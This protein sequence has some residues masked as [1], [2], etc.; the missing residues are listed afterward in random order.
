VVD[1]K[2]QRNEA[3]DTFTKEGFEG[4]PAGKTNLWADG[5][6]FKAV[7][8]E[9]PDVYDLNGYDR[10]VAMTDV[11][12]GEFYIFDLFRVR[13]GSDHARMTY[14]T[15]ATASSEGLDVKPGPDFGHETQLRRFKTD[16]SAKPGWSVDWKIEDR[17][18]QLSPGEEVHL[19]LTDLTDGAEASLA[20]AWIAKSTTS[21]DDGEWIPCVVTRRQGQGGTL[22]SDFVGIL[23]PY[24][25]R[26]F[27]ASARRLPARSG[28]IAA[29]VTLVD[30]RKD[31]WILG[32]P[33]KRPPE[34][35]INQGDE[36]RFAGDMAFIR[37][38]ANGEPENFSIFG[39]RM[40]HAGG[41]DVELAPGSGFEEIDLE[42]GHAI[43][44][45]GSKDAVVSVKYNGSSIPLH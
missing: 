24:K 14:S 39:G 35:K 34:I 10:T 29:E 36:V 21:T 33:S 15:F 13:G 42:N 11:T 41:W 4:L 18:R 9:A 45:S 20:E 1:G 5:K 8:A 43:L 30:G 2:N 40:L 27:I 16:P 3:S 38:K 25:S 23:Q 17:F 32:T 26:P 31:L 28:R 7:R 12:D 19:R 6:S 37:R 22:E 44:R